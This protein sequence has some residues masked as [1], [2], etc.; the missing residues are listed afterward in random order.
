[1]RVLSHCST[2]CITKTTVSDDQEFRLH[3]LKSCVV[4]SFQLVRGTCER[5][6]CANND[7]W[8]WCE[9]T[10]KDIF[11]MEKFKETKESEIWRRVLSGGLEVQRAWVKQGR[12]GSCG[13]CGKRE[14]DLEQCSLHGV[15]YSGAQT[16]EDL[17][18]ISN[19][20]QAASNL[21][22]KAV[23]SYWSS[24]PKDS[25]VS[26]PSWETKLKFF[27]GKSHESASSM[28]RREAD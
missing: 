3:L 25:K 24:K 2:H 12:C 14:I 1:M 26:R 9:M 7:S 11:T 13:Y 19:G 20:V 16:R 8:I 18:S 17:I 21:L 27:L 10:S 4:I 6:S 23:L 22:K 5:E 28:D 15:R